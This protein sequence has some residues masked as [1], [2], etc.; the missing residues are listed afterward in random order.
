MYVCMYLC[1]YVC[2]YVCGYVNACSHIYNNDV[3]L[4]G[5]ETETYIEHGI[6]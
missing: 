1:M 3:E 6:M 4:N 2:M 5:E